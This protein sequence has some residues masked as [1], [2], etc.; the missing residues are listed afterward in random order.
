[1]KVK[2]RDRALEIP[3]LLVDLAELEREI[4]AGRVAGGDPLERFDEP[5]GLTGPPED[6]RAHVLDD[7]ARPI[8][9]CRSVGPACRGL[10]LPTLLEVELCHTKRDPESGRTRPLYEYTW[11]HTTLHAI[12]VDPTITYL[13]SLFPPD[14]GLEQVLAMHEHF[15]DEVP[16][17]VELVR[18]QG[19]VAYAGLQL[20]RYTTRE[21]VADGELRDIEFDVQVDRSSWIALRIFATAHTNPIFVHVGDQPIRASKKSID[22]CIKSVDQCWKKKSPHI[23]EGAERD[24]AKKAYDAAKAEYEKRLA[25]CDVD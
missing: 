17:H 2:P 4:G 24:A 6:P 15:G 20:V 11:N 10:E 19:R 21:I 8:D 16:M 14:G 7:R 9:L 18:W 13:Q 3:L 23:R 5:V 22:W 25:Q 12:N 1:M